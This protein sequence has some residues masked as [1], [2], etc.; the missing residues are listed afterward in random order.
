MFYLL[1]HFFISTFPANTRLRLYV[2]NIVV[3]FRQ[4]L[5]PIFRSKIICPDIEIEEIDNSLDF[6]ASPVRSSNAN[7]ALLNPAQSISRPPS[8]L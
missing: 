6:C 3:F 4:G 8:R 5:R 1:L 7:N 2:F